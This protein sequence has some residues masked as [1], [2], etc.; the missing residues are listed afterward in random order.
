VKRRHVPARKWKN[1]NMDKP[2]KHRK[3]TVMDS[4]FHL[5][6]LGFKEMFPFLFMKES[7]WLGMEKEAGQMEQSSL[8]DS[9]KL[10][11]GHGKKLK[12]FVAIPSYGP[13]NSLNKHIDIYIL[14]YL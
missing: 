5:L 10:M 6:L 9:T 13:P 3:V 8:T 12:V 11:I 14:I 2:V 1:M 7:T 4:L